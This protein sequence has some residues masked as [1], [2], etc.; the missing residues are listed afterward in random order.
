M[1]IMFFSLLARRRLTRLH[2][3]AT[4][5]VPGREG[6]DCSDPRYARGPGTAN[7]TFGR[8]PSSWPC[9][10]GQPK[11]TRTKEQERGRLSTGVEDA[12]TPR[13][14]SVMSMFKVYVPLASAVGCTEEGFG[15]VEGRVAGWGRGVISVW[16]RLNGSVSLATPISPASTPGV[17]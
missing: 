11:Q 15:W 3:R 5:A 14:D 7:L 12:A 16:L 10:Y 1:L 13:T 9:G 4:L 8:G 2:L 17:H 6:C